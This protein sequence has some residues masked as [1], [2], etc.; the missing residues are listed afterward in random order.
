MVLPVVLGTIAGQSS[1]PTDVSVATSSSGNYDDSFVI[2]FQNGFSSGTAFTDHDGSTANVSID[3]ST[4]DSHYSGEG[5]MDMKIK[6]YMRATGAT[7]YVWT[8]SITN[9][10]SNVDGVSQSTL[11][12]VLVQDATGDGCIN[13]N[14][15]HGETRP[16]HP[17]A[18]DTLVLALTGTATN[19]DGN[20]A[21]TITKTL[22]WT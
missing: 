12:S 20:T 15:D 11:P 5:D 10:L 4:W 1:T 17:V 8:L 13:V 6:A 3:T 18:G 2:D 16:S 19:S 22:T 7:S 21:A 9:N 14:I